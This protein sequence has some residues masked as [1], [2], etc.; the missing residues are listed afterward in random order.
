MKKITNKIKRLLGHAS[1]WELCAYSFATKIKKEKEAF[2][3]TNTRQ[4]TRCAKKRLVWYAGKLS[5]N[6]MTTSLCNLIHFLGDQDYEHI[7]L[8]LCEKGQM[9]TK[10]QEMFPSFVR[11][12]PFYGIYPTLHEVFARVFYFLFPRDKKGIWKK[13]DRMYER[14]AGTFFLTQ[15]PD[16]VI[17]FTGYDR[18]AIGLFAYAPCKS[19]I[20]VHNDKGK[21][22]EKKH[23]EDGIFLRH[24]LKKYDYVVPVSQ[25]I[26]EGL[27]AFDVEKD[28]VHVVNNIHDDEKVKKRAEA[29]IQFSADTTCVL[30]QEE[31]KKWLFE[32]DADV[33]ITIGRFVPQKGHKLLLQAFAK[34][35]ESYPDT[36]LVIIGGY[37]ALFTQ[38]MEW[39][40]ELSLT[41][42]VLLIRQ[43]PNPMPVLKHCQL[44]ILSSYFEGQGLVL[45]EAV[46]LGVPVLS[47]RVNGPKEFMTKYGGALVEP[48]VKGLVQG[49]FAYKEGRIKPLQIDFEEYNKKCLA[50][51]K[52]IL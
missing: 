35:R 32:G 23:G 33:F 26:A 17:Q 1:F 27:I 20:F 15:C 8:V 16:V 18:D 12:L 11:V 25:D 43:L 19:I 9:P 14:N 2:E 22:T 31:T 47:T 49:M 38:T 3:K 28:R 29:Q 45:F 40:R 42:H 21:E 36:K 13:L 44:F 51:M 7:L 10:Q 46:S 24:Y 48:S 52:Q 4:T 50:D 6:G 30:S 39:V 41:D 34:Y 5:M 37:G